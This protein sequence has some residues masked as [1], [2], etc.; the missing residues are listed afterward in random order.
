MFLCGGCTRYWQWKR[1]NPIN[2]MYKSWNHIRIF[3]EY[4]FIYY[5]VSCINNYLT[6]VFH[7]VTAMRPT[8]NTILESFYVETQ[9][10]DILRIPS[11]HLHQCE[12]IFIYLSDTIIFNPRWSLNIP[13][14]LWPL[15]KELKNSTEIYL[16][17]SVEFYVPRREAALSVEKQ[18]QDKCLYDCIPTGDQNLLNLFP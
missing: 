1:N 7:F 5:H 6:H 15:Q 12:H 3:Y 17:L 18:N 8:C 11:T 10:T 13:K 14:D 9:S 2:S 16:F 4:V